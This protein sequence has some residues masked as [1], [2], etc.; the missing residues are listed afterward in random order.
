MASG[1]KGAYLEHGTGVNTCVHNDS[2]SLKCSDSQAEP[3]LSTLATV[4]HSVFDVTVPRETQRGLAYMFTKNSDAGLK[5][6]VK[7]FNSSTKNKH[8]T[9]NEILATWLSTHLPQLD[10]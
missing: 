10:V 7:F 2:S 1:C 8:L 6:E 4:C 9:H 5:L 3:H